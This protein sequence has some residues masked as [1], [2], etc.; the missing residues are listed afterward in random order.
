MIAVATVAS[1]GL[2]SVTS[3]SALPV[4]TPN[5]VTVGSLQ[6]VTFTSTVACSWDLPAG[7]SAIDV[8]A[9]GGGGGGGADGGDGG[10]GG[11][12]REVV[13]APVTTPMTLDIQLGDGGT[14]GIWA[15][16]TSATDGTDTAVFWSG[17]LQVIAKGGLGGNNFNGTNAGNG[18]GGTGGTGGSGRAGGNGGSNANFGPVQGGAGS[19]GNAT[20][21]PGSTMTFGGGGGGGIC[22]TSPS[23][24]NI[25][26][27]AGGAGG[28]GNGATHTQNVGDTAG[29]P[30]QA[31]TGGGG[32]GGAS[33]NGATETFSPSNNGVTRLTNG[34]NGGT[35]IVIVTFAALPSP[36]TTLA[37]TT[38]VAATT[39]STLVTNAAS[40]TTTTLNNVVMPVT[41]TTAAARVVS[42]SGGAV[43]STTT[44]EPSST[45]TSM[46]PGAAVTTTVVD[47]NSSPSPAAAEPARIVSPSLNLATF[48][49]S[50]PRL[51][52]MTTTI[53]AGTGAGGGSFAL[54]PVGLL[55]GST[56]TVSL[57]PGGTVLATRTVGADGAS[58]FSAVLP[59]GLGAGF[60][61]VMMSGTS[62]ADGPISSIIHFE[63]DD[64]GL[65]TALLP[66]YETVGS[67]PSD[68]TIARAI[69]AGVAP[70]D[71]V[72]EVS[73]TAVITTTAVVLMGLVGAAGAG[74]SLSS[75][76]GSRAVA[77]RNGRSTTRRA[78]RRAAPDTPGGT[79]TESSPSGSHDAAD[80]GG[81]DSSSE[82]SFGSTD[83]NL[84]GATDAEDE[85][86]GDR[87][88]PW[89]TAGY[90]HVDSLL[91]RAVRHTSTR[92]VLATRLLQDGMW[93]RAVAGTGEV[94]VWAAGL[95]L[96][97]TAAASTGSLAIAPSA[98]FVATIVVPSLLNGLAGAIAWSAFV[99]V[100]ALNG[101]ISNIFD[102][103][104]M[105][106]M[107]FLFVALPSIASAIRPLYDDGS[108]S[109]I[110]RVGDYVMMPVFL[111]YGAAGI[112]SALNGLSGLSLVQ[113]HDATVLRNVVFVA[114]IARLA[115]EDTVRRGFPVRAVA[116]TIEPDGEPGI[117][118][119]IAQKLV[120]ASLY[121]MAIVTFYG[122][123]IR[124]AVMI[125]LVSFVP[126]LGL[127]DAHF[128]NFTSVHRWFPRGI[129]RTVIMIFVGTWYGRFILSLADNPADTRRIAVF[130]LLP[131][132]VLGLIDCFAREGGEWEDRPAKHVAGFAL[133]LVSL[134]VLLGIVSV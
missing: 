110:H 36:T 41:T 86:W 27:R 76:G 104:T 3:T 50:S 11:E 51:M 97:I 31:N 81:R 29:S 77:A 52:Q 82:G 62:E 92:S 111:A 117:A 115:V 12:I 79:V 5:S 66:A 61:S 7:V 40:Q 39:T 35:G 21:I 130:L 119:E 20:T 107:G 87:L 4:C 16:N 47:T 49:S 33:C 28:G 60:H 26:A 8:V 32:G 124:A 129:L 120:A 118:S 89:I 83:A 46:S 71:V 23:Y 30:G 88:R 65:V 127:F 2:L 95:V 102:I 125:A 56:V 109:F 105:I 93:M 85:R 54:S 75:A 48:T 123:G 100:V 72:R 106:G 43:P 57:F 70:Y 19:A 101:N 15:T 128:P 6:V 113:P 131:G 90:S 73:S 38:T 58:S 17:A 9:V 42:A 80:T 94:A 98:A 24:A 22:A 84:L 1:P 121:T 126:V 64:S 34:G 122:W 114:A 103:R 59:S 55:P 18:V 45:T 10:G 53:R 63:T 68:A 44:T 96:G 14:G 116:V 91:R 134:A 67:V 13:D 69:D 99:A 25:T 112:Y 132:V 78:N 108:R 74:M 37:P 133:W